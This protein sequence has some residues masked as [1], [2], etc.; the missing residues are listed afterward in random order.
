MRLSFNMKRK[1]LLIRGGVDMKF[2]FTI[3]VTIEQG[4]RLGFTLLIL[5]NYNETAKT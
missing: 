5:E 4:K 3:F 2:N 1:K